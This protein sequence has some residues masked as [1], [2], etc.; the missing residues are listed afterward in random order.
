MNKIDQSILTLT[1]FTLKALLDKEYWKL[2]GYKSRP[3]RGKIF[4]GFVNKSKIAKETF[5]EKELLLLSLIDI[6]EAIKISNLSEEEKILYLTGILSELFTPLHKS[7]FF[8]N[9]DD[10]FEFTK[11]GLIDYKGNDILS[12]FP[13][14]AKQ[15]LNQDQMKSIHSGVLLLLALSPNQLTNGFTLDRNKLQFFLINIESSEKLSFPLEKDKVS[16]YTKAA[17]QMIHI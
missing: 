15:S 17:S 5:I 10:F 9:D 8:E 1:G 7:G 2:F 16:T 13:K 12:A 6:V 4:K 11:K 3:K 14:R